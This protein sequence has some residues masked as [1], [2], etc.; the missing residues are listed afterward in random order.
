MRK[1][2]ALRN[3]TRKLALASILKA[4]SSSLRT[5]KVRRGSATRSFVDEAVSLDDAMRSPHARNPVKNEISTKPKLIC[6]SKNPSHR[7]CY[8]RQMGARIQYS[9]IC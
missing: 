8:F 9:N 2:W 3:L 1:L 5:K 7:H 6:H 4:P